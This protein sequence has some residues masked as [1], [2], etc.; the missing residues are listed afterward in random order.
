MEAVV[1]DWYVEVKGKERIFRVS[2]DNTFDEPVGGA[3][4]D[5]R[6]AHWYGRRTNPQL[7][8]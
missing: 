6:P 1:G 2:Y 8:C 5:G 7:W 4:P 3:K